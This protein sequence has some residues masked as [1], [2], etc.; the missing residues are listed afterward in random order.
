LYRDP[1][2]LTPVISNLLDN[3]VHACDPTGTIDV[4]VSVEGARAVL[5]VQDEGPGVPPDQRDRIFERL[6]RRD[7]TRS[8]HRGGIGLGLRIARAHSGDL[9]RR[10]RAGGDGAAFRLR[11]PVIG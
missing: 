11:L 7:A 6:V 10:T 5:D 4:T 3:A 8:P 9:T 1:D 2:R